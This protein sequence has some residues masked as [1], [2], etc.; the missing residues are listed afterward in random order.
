MTVKQF[1]KSKSFKCIVALLSILLV[2]GVFLT[3]MYGFLEVSNGEK[4]QRS[5]A[6][7]YS[8]IDVKV[9]GLDN[10]KEIEIDS[11]VSDPK[12]FVSETVHVEKAE[13]SEMYKIVFTSEGREYT[14][15]LVTSKGLEGYDNGSVT[16]SVAISVENGSISG[17][18]KVS[19]QSNVGQSFISRVGENALGEFSTLYQSG[20][21]SFSQEM[22][23]G[24]TT[25][26]TKNAICNA[27]NGALTYVRD[28]LGE[29]VQQ[30]GNA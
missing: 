14:H 5:I 8:G 21:T 15:Y 18:Y 22:I 29:L 25:Q 26:R 10:G 27:V 28:Y 2:C 12:S 3:I 1:F 19:I 9:Y 11:S 16:C 4:L 30:G 24:A 23:T 13:I 7:V 6:K 17:I 20:T